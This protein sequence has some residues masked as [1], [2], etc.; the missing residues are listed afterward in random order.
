MG[1]N[2]TVGVAK[3][4]I[5]EPHN[6]ADLALAEMLLERGD[7]Q[8]AQDVLQHTDTTVRDSHSKELSEKKKQLQDA[9]NGARSGRR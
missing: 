4:P 2:I 9:V 3:R 7:W 5:N 1:Q 8:S 6:R